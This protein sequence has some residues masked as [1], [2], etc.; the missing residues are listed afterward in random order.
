VAAYHHE[1][2]EA[3][4]AHRPVLPCVPTHRRNAAGAV[5][6]VAIRASFLQS[7]ELPTSIL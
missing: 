4:H 7:A 6:A 3:E 5:L 2:R 1:L